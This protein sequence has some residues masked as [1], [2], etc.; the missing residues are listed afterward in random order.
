MSQAEEL[1]NSISEED[2]SVA[3]VNP[4]TEEHIV[5]GHNRVITVP[6]SLK[7]IAVQYDHNIETVVFDCPRYWDEH[8]LSKMKVYINYMTPDN[9]PGCYPAGNLT[10]DETDNS[11]MHFEWTI[12]RNVTLAKGILKFLVCIRKVDDE[13]NESNHWNSELNQE[14]TISEGLECEETILEEYPDIITAILLRLDAIEAV[15]PENV[16]TIISRLDEIESQLSDL[17]TGAPMLITTIPKG[18]VKGDVNGDGIVDNSDYELMMQYRAGEIAEDAL[19]LE[20]ADVNNDGNINVTDVT[21]LNKYIEGDNAGYIA[22]MN[23][24]VHVWYWDPDLKQYIFNISIQDVTANTSAILIPERPISNEVLISA[25]C[26][27]GMIRLH[28]NA[29][30]TEAFKCGVIYMDGDGSVV[31]SNLIDATGSAGATEE[32]IAQIQKNADDIAALPVKVNDGYTDIE[33]LRQVTSMSITKSDSTITVTTILEGN[34]SSESV[35]TLDLDGRP[36][37]IVTDGIEC[38]VT[39]SG[40]DT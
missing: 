34:Q 26:L 15:Q 11:I 18:P 21:I 12:S 39:W 23:D 28:F 32:Q 30:P 27:D 16:G 3:T 33:G 20:A 6:Q 22:D 4:S 8:D 36:T 2:I 13:G 29:C 7:K 10:I 1:L 9:R 31:I 17:G 19:D 35:I 5:I 25:E 40:F 14:M 37:K 38:P 24:I